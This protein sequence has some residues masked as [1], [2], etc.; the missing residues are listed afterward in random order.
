[1]P[2]PS[3]GPC[4]DGSIDLLWNT[5]R[6]KLLINV[7]PNDSEASDFYGETPDGLIVKGNF[8]P[9]TH[10]FGFLDWLIEQ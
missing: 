10:K 3:I 6:F 2:P 4:P 7:Q 5:D 9:S 8:R 1:M